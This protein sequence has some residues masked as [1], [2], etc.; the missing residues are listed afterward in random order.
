M[1]SW[2]QRYAIT[3]LVALFAFTA[4]DAYSRPNHEVR[5]GAVI[6][7][8]VVWPIAVTIAAGSAVGEMARERTGA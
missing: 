6:V 1:K 3:C 5:V 4:W 2:L 8:A 7:L